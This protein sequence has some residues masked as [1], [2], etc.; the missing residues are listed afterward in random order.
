MG[1]ID[2]TDRKISS[3]N[4]LFFWKQPTANEPESATFPEQ[5][6]VEGEA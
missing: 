2:G 5:E 3:H 4:R 6:T 1:E